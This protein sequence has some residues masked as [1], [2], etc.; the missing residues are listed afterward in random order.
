LWGAAWTPGIINNANFGVSVQANAANAI[1]SVDHA[2]VTITYNAPLPIEIDTFQLS[3]NENMVLASVSAFTQMGK[4][5][6]YVL[7]KVDGT[8]IYPVDSMSVTGSHFIQQFVLKDN[9]PT[10]GQNYYRLRIEQKKENQDFRYSGVEVISYSSVK[11]GLRIYPNP[12][13]SY[14]FIE[15]EDLIQKVEI[16][17]AMGKQVEISMTIV[18]GNKLKLLNVYEK[19]IYTVLVETP[20][21][22]QMH[23]VLVN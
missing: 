22:T 9:S 14:L 17:D 4:F 3:L 23:K 2:R 21:N 5:Y 1:A 10:C 11:S 13:T 12:M 8:S 19:G 20:S 6:K 15:S 16:Y 7:E 18:S